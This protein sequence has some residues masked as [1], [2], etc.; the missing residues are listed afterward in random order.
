MALTG[1][2]N[3]HYF[4][5]VFEQEWKRASRHNYAVSL[6]LLGIDQFEKVNDTYLAGDECLKELACTIRTSLRRPADIVARYGGEEFVAVL[7]YIE[8]ELRLNLQIRS[9][10]GLLR[11]P[12]TA[13]V[14]KSK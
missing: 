5:V 9:E 12:T 13:M 10:R 3:R 4:D 8:R 6:I 1:I 14:K 2:K 7:P 11:A